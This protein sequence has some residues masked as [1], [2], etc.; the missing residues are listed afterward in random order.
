MVNMS[1]TFVNPS[2]SWKR[3]PWITHRMSQVHL[4]QL[5]HE[6]CFVS[7]A[8]MRRPQWSKMLDFLLSIFSDRFLPFPYFCS[9]MLL[10][11]MRFLPYSPVSAYLRN[12]LQ[13]SF[14]QKDVPKTVSP[15]LLE[16]F[17]PQPGSRFAFYV[18]KAF[19]ELEATFMVGYL[20]NFS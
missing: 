4:R 8:M 7:F 9:I 12:I 18:M 20:Y 2:G 15:V 10:W 16:A 19:S 17:A 14:S 1:I 3:L 11:A 13:L 5:I 6:V